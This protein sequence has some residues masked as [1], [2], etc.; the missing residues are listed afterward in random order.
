VEEY[1]NEKPI[2]AMMARTTKKTIFFLGKFFDLL[3]LF[4]TNY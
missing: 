4:S 1:T 2:T 3:P